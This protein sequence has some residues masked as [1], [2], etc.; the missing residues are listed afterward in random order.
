LASY[1][2]NIKSSLIQPAN[3]SEVLVFMTDHDLKYPDWQA[4]LQDVILEFDLG[5]LPG[6]ILLVENLI[7]QRLQSL[8]ATNGDAD[9]MQAITEA[10]NLLRTVKKERLEFPDWS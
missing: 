10:V 5:K 9:E 4:P 8:R 2:S 7:F 1:P 6:K 3:E